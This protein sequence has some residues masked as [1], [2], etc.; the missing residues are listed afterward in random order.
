MDNVLK[1]ASPNPEIL[2]GL[3]GC[4]HY[5]GTFRPDW[6]TDN[7]PARRCPGI[8][9]L[10]SQSVVVTA[11]TDIEL[12]V[13]DNHVRARTLQPTSVLANVQS[14]PPSIGGAFFETAGGV[15]HIII[16]FNAF[17]VAEH[18]VLRSM[19]LPS[20]YHDKNL[21]TYPK[22][23][24]PGILGYTAEY[25]VGVAVALLV[26]NKPDPHVIERGESLGMLWFDKKFSSIQ[27]IHDANLPMMQP[28]VANYR[29]ACKHARGCE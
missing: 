18:G 29:K 23:A 10:F 6:W 26:P 7:V 13:T 3:A 1:F 17:P 5:A 27:F 21:V 8:A 12:S 19:N 14:H 11:P 20:T 28:S 22:Y 25:P 16:R 4:I 9:D 24:A 15:S 2:E